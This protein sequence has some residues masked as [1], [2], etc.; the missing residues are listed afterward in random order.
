MK[1]NDL[2]IVSFDAPNLFNIHEFIPNLDDFTAF[3]IRG[4]TFDKDSGYLVYA[5]DINKRSEV[6]TCDK[7]GNT[8]L[9]HIEDLNILEQSCHSRKLWL[10][11]LNEFKV[12]NRTEQNLFPEE[13]NI[14]SVFYPK[15]DTITSYYAEDPEPYI[16]E[17]EVKDF[18]ASEVYDGNAETVTIPREYKN[19]TYCSFEDCDNI[20]KI[21]QIVLQGNKNFGD[22]VG[23]PFHRLINLESFVVENSNNLETI[24][25]VL[26]F[27]VDEQAYIEDLCDMI[28]HMEVKSGKVLLSVPQNYNVKDFII[29]EG[30]VAVRHSAFFNCK[31]IESITFPT[32]ITELGFVALGG[33]DNLKRVYVPNHRI[34]F[35]CDHYDEL[36]PFSFSVYPLNPEEGLDEEVI[37]Q[38]KLISDICSGKEVKAEDFHLLHRDDVNN[39]KEGDG[40]P[41]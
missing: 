28:I 16:D 3:E 41:F 18:N 26:Y 9:F 14:D 7:E 24:D 30:V 38:W 6:R 10:C 37:A 23:T 19:V 39:N 25:G 4:Y 34:D 29:P 21:K 17:E 27:N 35:P 11:N 33:M 1:N 5:M 12:V 15:S 40:M 32:S 31:N 2:H 36:E 20:E 8:V 13:P 22:D